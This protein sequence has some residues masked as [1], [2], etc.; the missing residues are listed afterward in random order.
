[1]RIIDS[2]NGRIFFFFFFRVAGPRNLLLLGRSIY[3]REVW[4]G[5]RGLVELV[6]KSERDRGK[7]RKTG[8]N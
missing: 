6:Y 8:L 1:M 3:H 7:R 4:V 2:V 5:G